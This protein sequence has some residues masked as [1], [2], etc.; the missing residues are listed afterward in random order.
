MIAC[1][2]LPLREFGQHAFDA[3]PKGFE[4]AFHG[5]PKLIDHHVRVAVN[6]SSTFV[7]AAPSVEC[8]FASLKF[9]G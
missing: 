3:E 5:A 4:I 7:G 8:P 1:Q 9:R 6:E 2:T